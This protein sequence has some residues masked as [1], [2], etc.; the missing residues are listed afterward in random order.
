[1]SLQSSIKPIWFDVAQFQLLSHPKNDNAALPSLRIGARLR[2]ERGDLVQTQHAWRS[3]IA[4]N[5]GR[6]SR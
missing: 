6:R 2:H 4:D 3:F 1:V 5:K